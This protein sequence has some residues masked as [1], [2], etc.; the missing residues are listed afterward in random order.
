MSD[1]FIP[2]DIVHHLTPQVLNLVLEPE[3][4]LPIIEAGEHEVGGPFSPVLGKLVKLPIIHIYSFPLL[5]WVKIMCKECKVYLKQCTLL[6]AY[7]TEL[8]NGDV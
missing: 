3:P 2:G 7:L 6:A 1:V 4:L 8:N 5:A